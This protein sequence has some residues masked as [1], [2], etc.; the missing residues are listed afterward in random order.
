M[1]SNSNDQPWVPGCREG[2]E[3]KA[4]KDEL[5]TRI[6]VIKLSLCSRVGAAAVR[7]EN[8]KEGDLGLQRRKVKF[9]L[10]PGR[11]VQS[12]DKVQVMTLQVGNR[13]EIQELRWEFPLWR[14]GLKL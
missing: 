1:E 9:I 5:N 14:S 12:D 4:L 13:N 3:D 2:L 10:E 8:W 11:E 6:K 7:C